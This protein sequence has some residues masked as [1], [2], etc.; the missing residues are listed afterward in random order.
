MIT[1]YDNYYTKI[2]T[3]KKRVKITFMIDATW[4]NQFLTVGTTA[5]I[6][7]VGRIVGH[8]MDMNKMEREY[9]YNQW[10]YNLKD[11]EKARNNTNKWVV[12]GRLFLTLFMTVS[13]LGALVVAAFFGWTV[14]IE[15]IHKTGWLS[16]FIFGPSKAVWHQFRGFTVPSIC[17]FYI[18]AIIG[19]YFGGRITSS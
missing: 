17:W 11:Q 10:K 9:R 18:S 1:I 2:L 16:H 8:L 13:V 5:G 3:N 15:T 4:A 12:M 6:R 7:T 14:N 19:F